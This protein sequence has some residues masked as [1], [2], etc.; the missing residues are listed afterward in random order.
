MISQCFSIDLLVYTPKHTR[1]I[2]K[3]D[4]RGCYLNGQSVDIIWSS[5]VDT[6]IAT[7]GREP[8]GVPKTRYKQPATFTPKLTAVK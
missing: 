6:V 1:N 5:K 4:P 7:V 3:H 2:Y 8:P